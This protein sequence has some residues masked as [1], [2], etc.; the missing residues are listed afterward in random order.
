MTDANVATALTT[1]KTYATNI[2]KDLAGFVLPVG[3]NLSDP[4]AWQLGGHTLLSDGTV[5]T[6]TFDGTALA[7]SGLIYAPAATAFKSNLNCVADDWT[8]VGDVA[9]QLFDAT[10]V[11]IGN[12]PM[13]SAVA[14]IGDEV[15]LPGTQTFFRFM[16]NTAGGTF[17]VCCSN[18]RHGVR[19]SV[20]FCAVHATV[21]HTR[22][23]GLSSNSVPPILSA[24][25]QPLR[26]HHSQEG[27]RAWLLSGGRLGDRR[28]RFRLR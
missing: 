5:T 8:G 23:R 15:T 10:G 7:V 2:A 22:W 6:T 9:I 26:T 19:R 18:L 17:S 3:A 24:V 27:I 14:D 25:S 21:T 28:W 11:Y 12:Q 20:R 1:S 13:P 4:S 16:T